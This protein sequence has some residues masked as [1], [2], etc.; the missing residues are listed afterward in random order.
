M[1]IFVCASSLM[2]QLFGSW[3]CAKISNTGII[4]IQEISSHISLL[5]VFF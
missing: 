2:T 5:D 4:I 3:S 1:H